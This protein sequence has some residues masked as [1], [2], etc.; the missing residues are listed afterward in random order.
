MIGA[1]LSGSITPQQ[2]A[3][4]AATGTLAQGLS[5]EDRQAQALR[6]LGVAKAVLVSLNRS[7]LV[8]KVDEIS[9]ELG[10][11]GTP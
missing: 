10:V 9:T 8:R 5:R 2:A 4:A 3:L 6:Y 11:G 7:E 1:L